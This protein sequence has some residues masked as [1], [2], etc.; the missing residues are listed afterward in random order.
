MAAARI[1]FQNY[2]TNILFIPAEVTNAVIAQGYTSFN[3]FDYL[4]DDDIDRLASAIRR[5]GVA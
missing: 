3:D 2:L 1:A 4:D 5:P